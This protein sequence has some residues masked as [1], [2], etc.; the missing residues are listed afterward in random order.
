M[1]RPLAT[2]VSHALSRRALLRGA[3][4]GAA[5]LAGAALLGCA[6]DEPDEAA[7]PD[8]ATQAPGGGT[9]GGANPGDAMS[10]ASLDLGPA[11]QFALVSGWYRDE[12]ARY[13]DFGMASPVT[14]SGAVG[15]A[16]IWAF[17]TGMAAD[18]SPQFVE[19]QH[20]VVAVVPGDEG[21]SDLWEVRLVTV[22]AD[23]EADRIRSA[24]EVE[25]S[26]YP[27]TPAGLFVNCPVVPAGSTLE[28]GEELVQGWYRGERVF[29]PDFG[30]NPPAAIPIW[31]FATGMD[32]SGAPVFV[33]G[34]RNVI[35]SIPGQAGYS[36]FWDV[37]LVMVDEGYEANAIRSRE[38]VEMS[39]FEV[40]RP[41]LV[42]NCPVVS[43]TA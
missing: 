2:P 33:E 29:Y 32:A 7:T 10:A 40:V 16:P 1:H 42:V 21:Y 9:A 41:G 38:G 17:I 18:G 8:Q 12:E 34:Q 4:L 3:V 39:G 23:Y 27:V 22:P 6:D 43:P 36:A 13:Y 35:D 14:A 5:G 11:K 24:A 15:V 25:S 26:G 31:A 28:G 30:A 20:N 19:G 37:H